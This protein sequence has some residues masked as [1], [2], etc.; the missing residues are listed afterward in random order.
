RGEGER[1]QGSPLLFTSAPAEKNRPSPVRTV[2]TVSG[3]S[4][5]SLKAAMVSTMSLPPNALSDLGRLN[6]MMPIRPTISTMMSWYLLDDMAN[7]A[8]AGVRYRLIRF[9][10]GRP[11]NEGERDLFRCQSSC[12]KRHVSTS[13]I[14]L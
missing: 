4:F 14:L 7:T 10:I 5:S 2:K 12:L 13:T 11:T 1:K 8:G 9:L 3:C 6:L